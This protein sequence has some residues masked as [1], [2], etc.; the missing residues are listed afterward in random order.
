MLTVVCAQTRCV[1][2]SCACKFCC[3]VS[4]LT[5]RPVAIMRIW[6]TS[7]AEQDASLVSFTQAVSVNVQVPDGSAGA[8]TS[9]PPR[10]TVES[11]AVAD[12]DTRQSDG[13]RAYAAF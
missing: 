8:A 9:R 12:S 3:R 1:V 10:L 4:T 5:P 2:G 11:V 13:P 6:L 7:P